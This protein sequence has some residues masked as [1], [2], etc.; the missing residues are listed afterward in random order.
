MRIT[1]FSALSLAFHVMLLLMFWLWKPTVFLS[2]ETKRPVEVVY[3][4]NSKEK[5]KEKP[6]KTFVRQV[7][8]PEDLKFEDPAEAQFSSEVRQRVLQETRAKVSGLTKNRDHGPRYM[9]ET[10]PEKLQEQAR[11]KKKISKDGDEFTVFNPKQEIQKLQGGESTI[12]VKLPDNIAV[13]SFTALN[14][15]RNVYYTFY[16]RLEDMIYLRWAD[17]IKKA[18][19]TY[20]T[21]FKRRKLVGRSWKTDVVILLRPNGEF[22]QA[23]I[24]TPSGIE[25]FD[26]SPALAF[27]DARIFPNPPPEMVRSDGFIHISYSFVVD[28]GRVQ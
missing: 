12:S 27:Q 13:G 20:P 2:H 4:K 17:L 26:I 9:E 24:H 10:D 1:V 19:D 16:A 23:Q 8:V 18:V 3:V 15:D 5:E 6:E 25:M 22:H 11:E 21:D 7:Q 14:T 28:F